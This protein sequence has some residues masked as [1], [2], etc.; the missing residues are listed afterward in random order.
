MTARDRAGRFLTGHSGNPGGRPVMPEEVREA[1]QAATPAAVQV[2]FDGLRD[3][4]ARVR[5][6]CAR[7]ILD[8]ALGKPQQAPPIEGPADSAAQHLAALVEQARQRRAGLGERDALPQTL[9][10]N[11]PQGEQQDAPSVVTAD[12]QRTP[13]TKTAP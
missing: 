7:E 6:V 10:S 4:D 9:G 3:E 8:R 2:L 13:E 5:V 11:R 12:P 1:L